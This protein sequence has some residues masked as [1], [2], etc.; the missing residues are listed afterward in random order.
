MLNTCLKKPWIW[1]LWTES[2]NSD[3]H[4]FHQYQQNEQPSLILTELTEHI[5]DHD[6]HMTLEMQ[7]PGLGQPQS[8]G[9]VKPVNGIKWTKML[10]T[11]E[12]DIKLIIV[13]WP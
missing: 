5:K 9:E 3:S 1:I 12:L 10:M 4:Q 7:D 6:I 11:I 8:C 13:K 2:L